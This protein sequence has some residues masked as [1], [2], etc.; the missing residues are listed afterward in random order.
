MEE[1]AYLFLVISALREHGLLE[2]RQV[3]GSLTS[4]Y[5]MHIVNRYFPA[6]TDYSTLRYGMCTV[7]YSMLNLGVNTLNSPI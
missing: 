4:S 2:S 1:I 3:H 5:C 6:A 7:F